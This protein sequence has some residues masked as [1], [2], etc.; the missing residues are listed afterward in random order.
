[1][2]QVARAVICICVFLLGGVTILRAQTA[3]TYIYDELGR[4]VAVV[5]PGGDTAT[6][7]YDPV[8]NL[9]SIGR[10]SS[11]QLSVIEFSPN[12]GPIATGVTIYGTG[13]STN[14]NDNTV[15]FNGTLA[16]VTAATATNLTTTVPT[17]STSG[18][19][20]VTTSGGTASSGTSFTVTQ[21]T[22]P[23]ITSFTP[24][25]GTAGTALTVSGT[26]FDASAAN[27]R[28]KLNVAR[29][30]ISSHTTTTI[31]TTAPVGGSGRIA[32]TTPAGQALSAADF[33][34]PPS[35]Y[36]ASD[37]QYTSRMTFGD[38]RSV[39]I[40]TA[41]KIG[42]VVFDGTT[43][44]RT[45]LKVV[46]GPQSVVAIYN[47]DGSLHASR[48][49]GILTDLV[50]PALLPAT[51][52]Y[53]IRVDP[54]TTSTGTTTI[55]LYNVPPDASGGITPGGSSVTF[56][57][58]VP[59]QNAKYT[60]NGTLDQRVSLKVSAGPSGTVAIKNP[61][62]TTLGSTSINVIQSFIDTK[63]LAATGTYSVSV[64]YSAAN[65]GTVTLT[66]YDV[67][68]DVVGTIT[69]GG[70]PVTVSIP[71]PGQNGR[72]TFSGTTGQRVSLKIG[73]GPVASISMLNPDNTTLASAS[74][75]AVPTFIDTKTLGST[76]TYA[77]AIDPNGANTGDL[78]FTL[79][80]VPADT[81]G[82]VTI[83]GS[84]VA[85]T[86][87]TAGQNG[88]LTFTGSAG[89]QV[90]VQ[91]TSN[92]ISNLTVKLQKPDGSQLT[93]ATSGSASFN[94]STQTLPI[95]GTYTIV[96]DPG[97]WNT[98]SVNVRVT[99]P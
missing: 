28:V 98:G 77:I 78:T 37:V 51:G 34:I 33:F 7:S 32:V 42:L 88:S 55:T 57:S 59:G 46:P 74:S 11:S 85:V 54:N 5:T 65:T 12:G 62:D 64:D 27:N 91:N 67:P 1:M 58:T 86:I 49:I 94:L 16:T 44:Q 95:D 3:I 72:L 8:G 48:S 68:A 89:Q 60:F 73:G 84:S 25:I 19:I 53:A 96:I 82:T 71:T 75:A 52:T 10:F 76:G 35:P 80:D 45:S 81:T 56:S 23:T 17:G 36:T 63:T 43:G 13:F 39:A 2:S 90:T 20:S 9:L 70:S 66:L 99:N 47:P 79:Y 26:N 69:A 41:T 6:Y 24:T 38:S 22:V 97:Q 18:T 40:T 21:S 14:P 93:S 29:A 15:R 50:E 92:T 87:T 31:N 83:G 61:N 4:L 30:T